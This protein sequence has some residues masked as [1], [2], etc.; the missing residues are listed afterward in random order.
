VAEEEH[1]ELRQEIL[2]LE[3]QLRQQRQRTS[4]EI[5]EVKRQGPVYAEPP[6]IRKIN[7]DFLKGMKEVEKKEKAYE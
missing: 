5:E 3:I 4:Q 1:D 6:E 2:S 7:A